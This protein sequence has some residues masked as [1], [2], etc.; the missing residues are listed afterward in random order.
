MSDTDSESEGDKI[1][2][3]RRSVVVKFKFE[4][5]DS[6]SD[7]DDDSV[8][9]RPCNSARSA[10][11]KRSRKLPSTDSE[12]DDSAPNPRRIQA[13][14]SSS[15]S[16]KRR[17]CHARPY[18]LDMDDSSDSSW[19]PFDAAVTA[20]GGTVRTGTRS[21]RPIRASTSSL[22]ELGPSTSSPHKATHRLADV[23]SDAG[24]SSDDATEK[25]PICLHSF[26]DQEIGMPNVCEHNY[27]VPCIDEWSKNVQ[28]CPIDR[29]PF[30][31]IRVRANLDSSDCLRE[32]QVR[33]DS[34]G[35]KTDLDITH[36]EICNLSDRE[37]TM[38]LCDG[39]DQ[40]YHMEC[41]IPAMTEIPEG[42]WYCDNCFGSD[43]SEEDI[44]QLI[45]EME[46]EV[47][48]PETRLRVRRVAVP[49]ITRTRQSERI[50]AT[51]L[52]RRLGGE[53]DA[54]S[55]AAVPGNV[56]LNIDILFDASAHIS[57]V[58]RLIPYNNHDFGHNNNSTS[59]ASNRGNGSQTTED[60]TPP[61]KSPA[62]AHICRRIR[63]RQF[64]Q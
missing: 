6:S 55:D 32:I 5:T 41:L 13:A 18:I 19:S 9:H 64:R 57:S 52:S 26:R 60:N 48:I 38:L 51:I 21:P 23:Q 12:S 47:G 10:K 50:R 56:S 35:P 7:D 43:T 36:C 20:A 62:A 24:S 44:S 37:D 16:I 45:E 22:Y 42:S 31:T 14:S 49:R 2:R 17:D 53:S 58:R 8:S 61:K 63:C 30:T 33:A 28:T 11:M 1:R 4:D 25:C 40:G 27:C 46:S 34:S 3:S 54:A 59:N 29:K 39:C 15:A